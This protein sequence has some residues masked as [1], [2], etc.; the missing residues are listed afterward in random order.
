M[1]VIRHRTYTNA[2]P[3]FGNVTQFHGA[4]KG[5]GR[6]GV[7]SLP[8]MIAQET[9]GVLGSILEAPLRIGGP[10][11]LFRGGPLREQTPDRLYDLFSESGSFRGLTSAEFADFRDHAL[12]Q[13]Y[14]D[15]REHGTHAQRAFLDA[16]V[17]SRDNARALAETL[18]DS[19][20][21]IAMTG[22]AVEKQVLAAAA[23]IEHNV[24]PVV[25][26]QLPFGGD[27]HQDS[28]L[29]T[30]VT[31]TLAGIEGIRR[32][33]EE[34]TRRGVADRTTFA[35]LAVFGRTLG[36][37]NSGGR[38]HYG[39]DHAMVMFGPNVEPGLHGGLIDDGSSRRPLKAG[40][41]GDVPIEETLSAA[42]KTLAKAC[43]IP[44]DTIE[45]RIVGGRAL[46]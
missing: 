20:Q 25:T 14:R 12:D 46:F 45:E 39:D 43:G 34:L 24:A 38:N 21:P 13:I 31:E 8:S 17:R 35:Y 27:N 36:R 40:P 30:E 10:G 16:N 29:E 19:L 37:G 2:H 6:I 44:D 15:T 22:D 41:I 28:Q 9:A 26:I 7:E 23:L 32:L 3:E 11:Y 5:P 18:N 4:V 42:G 33:H 1:S